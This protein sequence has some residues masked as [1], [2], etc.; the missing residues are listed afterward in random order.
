MPN[1]IGTSHVISA[2]DVQVTAATASVTVRTP[3][4]DLPVILIPGVSASY[5][6]TNATWIY[7]LSW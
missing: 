7:T 5:L 6:D 3:G 2:T 1:L 4:T